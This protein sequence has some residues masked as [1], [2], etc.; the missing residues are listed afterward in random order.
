MEV[1]VDLGAKMCLVHKTDCS[2]ASFKN[3]IDGH[4]DGATETASSR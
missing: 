3:C 1:T 4:T 2:G